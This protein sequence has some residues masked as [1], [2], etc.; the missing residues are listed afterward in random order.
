MV[1]QSRRDTLKALSGSIG[2][3]TISGCMGG[4]AA[5]GDQVPELEFLTATSSQAPTDYEYSSRIVD[6]WNE[7]GFNVKHVPMETNARITKAIGE[8]DYQTWQ[9]G[10]GGAPDRIDPHFFTFSVYHSS[11]TDPGAFNFALYENSDYD[12]LAEEQQR[13]FDYEERKEIIHECQQILSDDQPRST[14]FSVTVADPYLSDRVSG[15]TDMPG[16]NSQSF[17][18][19][20][21]IEISGGDTFTIGNAGLPQTLNPLDTTTISNRDAQRLIYDRLFRIGTDFAPEP[22]AVD[23]YERTGETTVEMTIRDDM[24]FHDGE[25]VTAEDVVFSIEYQ[26]EYGLISGGLLS[27]I[28]NAEVTDD[29][30]VQLELE[31][32]FAPIFSNAFAY[33]FVLP[34]HIWKDIPDSVDADTPANWEN[35]EPVGSGPFEFESFTQDEE[36]KLTRYD[37][38]YEQPNIEE[39][40]WIEGPSGSVYDLVETEEIDAAAMGSTQNPQTTNRLSEL[41]HID[42]HEVPNHGVEDITYNNK[43]APFSHTPVRR[44]LDYAI[45]RQSIVEEVFLERATME[46]SHITSANER[47]HNPD[48]EKH[49]GADLELARQE[50]EDAGY[51][52]DGD[53]NIYYPPEYT[54]TDT[55]T[56]T[57]T[58]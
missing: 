26:Q 55:M 18:N 41:D 21:N 57:S 35:P 16:Q 50:L 51:E 45:P 19:V 7:L 36:L 11:Q 47:W 39:F 20:M 17:K 32:P 48:V 31:D 12:E 33:A 8:H 15:Y 3:L 52:W 25:D 27:P 53:G 37:D 24:T 10:W 1:S 2:V 4:D 56:A 29:T 44:A 34:K 14:P 49:G 5:E 38:Y 46:F 43:V 58:E 30:T 42:I 23:E 22:Y 40:V 54:P 13:I 28:T 6:N 9:I